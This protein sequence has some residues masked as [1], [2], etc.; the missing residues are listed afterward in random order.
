MT[1]PHLAADIWRRPVERSR[2]GL[3]SALWRLREAVSG[4]QWRPSAAYGGR[5]KPRGHSPM[6]VSHLAAVERSRRGHIALSLAASG[7]RQP[8]PSRRLAASGG[9]QL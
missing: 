6:T 9:R 3:T 7:G 1:Y 8:C 2:R 4:G 5:E